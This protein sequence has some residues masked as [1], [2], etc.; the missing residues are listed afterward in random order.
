[1]DKI[2][3]PYLQERIPQNVSEISE[4]LAEMPESLLVLVDGKSGS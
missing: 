3:D 4:K 2:Q 1:M